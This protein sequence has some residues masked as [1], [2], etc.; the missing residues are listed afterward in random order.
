MLYMV[1]VLA[2]LPRAGRWFLQRLQGSGVAQFS[3]LL[4]AVYLCA[5]SALMVGLEPIIGAFLA[6]LALNRL[7]PS[8]S[9]LASRTEF[10]GNALFIPFF[11]VSTGM[12]VDFGLMLR[13][14][15]VWWRSIWRSA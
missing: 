1:A 3:F 14:R 7:V 6:G 11:L 5:L 15:E 12:L 13:E 2:G 9:A 4:A 10:V 8:K